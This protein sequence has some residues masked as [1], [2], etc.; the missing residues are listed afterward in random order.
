MNSIIRT[1]IAR[2]TPIYADD[3]NA[4]GK[5]GAI[6]RNISG[7]NV[8]VDWTGI[9]FRDDADKQKT[10]FLQMSSALGPSGV[11]GAK[12]GR[13]KATFKFTTASSA[14]IAPTDIFD[15]PSSEDAVFYNQPELFNNPVTHWIAVDGT[16]Y[17]FADV[18]PIPNDLGRQ[19][20]EA[21]YAKAIRRFRVR[22]VGTTAY[23][24]YSYSN[25]GDDWTLLFTGNAC[26]GGA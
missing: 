15:F 22:V 23:V 24:E 26:P 13:L 11:Y 12:I 7:R 20:Y 6:T 1:Y 19:G 21:N 16:G 8:V 2:Q 9:H 18:S 10:A 4:L 25:D 14:V 3:M 5:A 17:S